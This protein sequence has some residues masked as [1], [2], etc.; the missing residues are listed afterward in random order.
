MLKAPDA[1]VDRIL[2]LG[3]SKDDINVAMNSDVRH[4]YF[5]HGDAP[6][7]REGGVE[8]GIAKGA[9]GG[10]MIGATLGAIVGAA[11]LTGAVSVAVATGGAAVPFLAGP[12]VAA[13]TGAGGGAAAGS[14]IGALAG[15]GAPGSQDL[16][17]DIEAG[18]VVV[19]VNA[20][21]EDLATVRSILH[22]DSNASSEVLSADANGSVAVNSRTTADIRGERDGMQ[23]ESAPIVNP[24]NGVRTDVQAQRSGM[25]DFS[26]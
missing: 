10:G 16:Q 9:A 6:H 19:A 3:Y 14:I 2:G 7:A 5:G 23:P 17:R 26:D 15:A 24:V 1:A 18:K 25:R 11:T 13:L 4:R 21:D 12:L 8:S 20:D 22:A